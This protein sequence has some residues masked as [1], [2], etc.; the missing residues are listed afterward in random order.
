M[1]LRKEKVKLIM[2]SLNHGMQIKQNLND[3]ILTTSDDD[4]LTTFKMPQ[5]VAR[6]ACAA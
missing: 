5:E 6:D 2:L 4:L 3:S 1:T